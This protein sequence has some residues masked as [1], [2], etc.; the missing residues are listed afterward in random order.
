MREI[1]IILPIF[2]DENTEVTAPGSHSC[3][4]RVHEW[5][6]DFKG[7]FYHHSISGFPAL[8]SHK[9]HLE[10][11]FKC[12]IL[13]LWILYQSEIEGEGRILKSSPGDSNGEWYPNH[14]LLFCLPECRNQDHLQVILLTPMSLATV[15][16]KLWGRGRSQTI[17]ESMKTMG[18][19]L[20]QAL[21]QI[22]HVCLRKLKPANPR[23]SA[24]GVC[25]LSFFSL[26]VSTHSHLWNKDMHPPGCLL[27]AIMR[28]SF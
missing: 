3:M 21:P 7:R 6:P 28:I 26:S 18:P 8:R 19:S 27:Q 16:H 4:W 11:L 10:N 12:H 17:W 24:P 15:V 22:L 13:Q 14:T 2:S 9:N 5:E 1:L 20:D 25:S 23:I